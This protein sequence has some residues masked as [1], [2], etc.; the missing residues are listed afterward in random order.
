M[1][2][3]ATLQF[4]DMMMTMDMTPPPSPTESILAQG[5]DM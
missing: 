2:Y 4:S 3:E 5:E 1:N